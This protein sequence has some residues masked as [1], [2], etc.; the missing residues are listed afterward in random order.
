M[1]TAGQIA[2]FGPGKVGQAFMDMC[3][4]RRNN[5]K[6]QEGAGFLKPFLMEV[7]DENGKVIP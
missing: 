6:A 4:L 1:S 3:S 2:A 7:M 5:P